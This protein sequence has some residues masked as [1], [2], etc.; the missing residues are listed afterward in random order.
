MYDCVN[1]NLLLSNGTVCR[2]A[3]GLVEYEE[4]WSKTC[5]LNVF[6]IYLS[7][8]LQIRIVIAR[9]TPHHTDCLHLNNDRKG[10]LTAFVF[11]VGSF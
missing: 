3:N 1:A 9:I 2:S 11:R 4:K 6:I 7:A 8:A 10:V 5:A